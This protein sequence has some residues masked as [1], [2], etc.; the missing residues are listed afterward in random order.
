MKLFG[1]YSATG[2]LVTNEISDRVH[3]LRNGSDQIVS[4]LLAYRKVDS[5]GDTEEF[6]V[7]PSVFEQEFCNGV[8]KTE[9]PSYYYVFGKRE[10]D[11]E[12]SESGES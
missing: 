7:P 9:K 10:S 4:N 6:W 1:G 11:G 5:N 12:A 2:L 8:N 3:D